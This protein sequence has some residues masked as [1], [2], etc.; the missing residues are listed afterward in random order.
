MSRNKGL[1]RDEELEVDDFFTNRGAFTLNKMSI[2]IKCKTAG[3]KELINSIK[4][5]EVT[6][7]SGPAGTGKTLIARELALKMAKLGHRVLLF[8][9]TDALGTFF[10]ECIV[11]PNIKASSIRQFALEQLKSSGK[12][13][14]EK[15]SPE[16]WDNLSFKAAAEGLPPEKDRWD[17]VIVDEG[18]DF[19]ENDWI[20]AEECSSTPY[21]CGKI[22]LLSQ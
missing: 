3:Q 10:K 21:R 13:I 20:L 6:I 12:I 14:P 22:G 11:H 18:Q 2:N 4:N 9:F 15:F 1:S 17:F 5:K 7:C 19:N 8:C 16:I